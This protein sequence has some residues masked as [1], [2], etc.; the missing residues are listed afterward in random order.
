MTGLTALERVEALKRERRAEL[1]ALESQAERVAAE[2]KLQADRA[3]DAAVADTLA[4]QGLEWLGEFRQGAGLD[5][6]E[7]CRDSESGGYYAYA[8]FAIPGHRPV[9]LSLLKRGD[10]WVYPADDAN[11][12]RVDLS[13]PADTRLRFEWCPTLADALLA[14]DR[15]RAVA[16]EI[17]Y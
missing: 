8:V 14:A 3:F 5:E 16:D 13:E 11:N 9:R 15:A 6:G 1:A 12:W 7:R 10:G 2:L 17:P 4:A